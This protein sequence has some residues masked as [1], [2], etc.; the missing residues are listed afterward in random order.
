MWGG[1]YPN[2]LAVGVNTYDGSTHKTFP[3]PHKAVILAD[4]SDTYKKIG[5][6]SM[7]MIS[8]HHMRSVVSLAISAIEFVE[9]GEKEYAVQII[10]NSQALAKYL[11]EYGFRVTIKDNYHSKN[12]QGWI[13]GSNIFSCFEVGELLFE[14][15][16]IVNPYN[17]SPQPRNPVLDWVLMKL[18]G[19]GSRRKT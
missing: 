3:G 1:Q 11:A 14:A 10:K 16:L 8:H 5:H 9:C 15:G 18:L 4:D 7:N 17:P 19:S 6:T 12:H 13:E 2:P